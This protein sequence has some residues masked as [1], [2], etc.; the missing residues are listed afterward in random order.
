MSPPKSS[1]AQLLQQGQFHHQQGRPELA[2]AC[3]LEILERQPRSFEA[4]HLLGLLKLQ[5]GDAEQAAVPLQRA[6]KANPEDPATQTLLGIAL[7][8]T[9]R[10]GAS[11]EHFRRAAM[12][13]PGNPEFHYNLGKALRSADRVEEAIGCYRQALSL[14]ADHADALNNLSEA[15]N[16]LERPEE[17]AQAAQAVIRLNPAHA[18]AWSNLGG[19][20]LLLE[21]A[22]AALES[23]DQ[24]LQ[25][26]PDLP[27]ALCNR[28]KALAKL[29]RIDESVAFI[30]QVISRFPASREAVFTRGLI[31]FEQGDLDGALADCKDALSMSPGYV[32]ALV[33]TGNIHLALGRHDAAIA[34]FDQALKHEPGHAAAHYNLGIT[35]LL[36]GQFE[37]GW[38]EYGWRFKTREFSKDAAVIRLPV[39]Q[40]GR[41][42]RLLVAAEQGIGD[43]IMYASM[44]GDLAGHRGNI[45]VALSDKLIP[46]FSRAFPQFR[47]VSLMD[48]VGELSG[49]DAYVSIGD[50]G[51]HFR[52]SLDRFITGRKPYLRADAGRAAQLR[53]AVSG[54]NA[55]IVCGLSWYSNNK[56]VGTQKSMALADL[57]RAFADLDCN[58][59]DLQYGDT[60]AERKAVRE[61][62]G[63][64]VMREPT[65]D[66]F[67]DIDGLA[68][69]VDACD[70]IVTISNTT[71]HLA[72]ALGKRVF[73]ML[74]HEIGRFWC[75]QTDREDTLWY[76]DVRIFRQPRDGDWASVLAEVREALAALPPAR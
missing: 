12:L 53:H 30:N 38:Q 22:G 56:S 71:A 61:A 19:A 24:A 10:T 4:L 66:T 73:L 59:I 37:R 76:P 52:R 44:L 32:P 55:R 67:N 47:F 72:G 64:E 13:A 45:S 42:A 14:K 69:L 11:L 15:L 29:G 20:Q 74:P 2:E 31:R 21:Q 60:E 43:Q 16:T 1:I 3:Y 54:G 40:G 63:I 28:A 35:L 39:W 58:W 65:V 34:D 23:L 48:T 5:G 27:R 50:L 51:L 8:E 62:G 70:V 36:T 33:C 7:Q 9:G 68:A 46:I 41:D 49:W 75:W 18:E 57:S 25:L 26:R 17:A 6:A